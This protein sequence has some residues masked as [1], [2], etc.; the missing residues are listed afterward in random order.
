MKVLEYKE[1]DTYV[2]AFTYSELN[3]FRDILGK[4]PGVAGTEVGVTFDQE[5]LDFTDYLFKELNLALKDI[6]NSKL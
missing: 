5:Q 3:I 6:D 1:R 2:V 4:N